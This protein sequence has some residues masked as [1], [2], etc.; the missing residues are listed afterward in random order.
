MTSCVAASPPLQSAFHVELEQGSAG[1]D[2]VGLITDADA[3]I[4]IIMGCG[5]YP[6]SSSRGWNTECD[7]RLGLQTV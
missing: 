3:M 5:I 4:R 7:E 1:P 2:I 6:S